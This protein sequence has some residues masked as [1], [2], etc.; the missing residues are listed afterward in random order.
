VV[1]YFLY[2]GVIHLSLAGAVMGSGIYS[3]KSSVG[4]TSVEIEVLATSPEHDTLPSMPHRP[5]SS[6]NPAELALS[7]ADK[8][9]GQ[10]TQINHLKAVQTIDSMD[11]LI[12]IGS[13]EYPAESLRRGHQG[14]VLAH[15][16]FDQSGQ[17]KTLKIIEPTVY[18]ELNRE[19]LRLL[20]KTRISN[21]GSPISQR[22]RVQFK[23]KD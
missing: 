21:S 6:D 18:S 10:N 11:R 3:N 22:V 15:L 5:S 8:D 9:Q 2:S 12:V 7:R 4:S 1:K 23:I 16:E 19:A 14:V 17:V 13:A 20:Q